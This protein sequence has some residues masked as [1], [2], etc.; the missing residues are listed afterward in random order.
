MTNLKKNPK[1]L[2]LKLASSTKP[3]LLYKEQ[4][5]NDLYKHGPACILPNL[6]L[7]SYYNASN[8]S[9]LNKLDINCVINVA[10]EINIT[11][12]PTIKEYHHM[13]WTHSQNNL[14]HVEFAQAIS[15]IQLAHSKRKNVFI[16]CQQGIERSAALVI[17]YLLCASRQLAKITCVENSLAGQNWSLDRALKYVQERAPGIRPNM[18]L[19]Y[20]LQEYEKSV[21]VPTKKHNIQTRTRRSESIILVLET[22]EL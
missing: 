18:E 10:S 19:L 1:K 17:A 5:K 9:Q 8:G 21:I 15:K 20:Q 2:A 11:T 6:Y 3:S 22:A 14:A 13:R 16:H 12:I 7:G 4:D